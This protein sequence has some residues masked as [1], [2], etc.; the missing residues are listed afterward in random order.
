MAIQVLGYAA[1]A[2]TLCT[3]CMKTMVPLRVCGIVANILF[4]SY[5]YLDHAYSILTLHAILLPLNSVRLYQMLQLIKHVREAARGDLDMAWLKPFMSARNI[6]TGNVLFR[7][8]DP[9]NETFFVVSGHFRLLESGISVEPGTFVGE[10]GL[11]A[12]NHART[13]SLQCIDKG[14]VL[15]I[16][17]DQLQQLYFQNPKFGF[18]L[19]QL[20]SR[21]LFE[22]INTLEDALSTRPPV[23][24]L[25]VEF[26][27]PYAEEAAPAT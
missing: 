11:L 5:G 15:E 3:F 25:H 23:P 24:V 8:G 2:V 17:Y 9:A 13:Q 4:M 21:R 10:L 22:N 26:S 20:I 27:A 16:T 14:S 7:K 18:Y 6:A 1:A 19:L 12:P